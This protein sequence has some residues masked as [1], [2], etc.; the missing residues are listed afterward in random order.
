M[1]AADIHLQITEVYGTEA[2]SN[3]KTRKWA[4]KFKDGRTNVH[5]EERS[6]RPSAITD[7]LMHTFETKIRGGRGS[8]LGQAWCFTGGLYAA[9]NNDQ[10]RCLLHNSTEALKSIVKQTVRHAVKRCFAPPR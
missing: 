6:G 3:S 10:L 1:S 7:N 4:R 9:R 2:M 5:D 8:V